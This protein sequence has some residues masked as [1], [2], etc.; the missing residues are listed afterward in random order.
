MSARSIQMKLSDYVAAFLAEQGVRYAFIVSGGASIHLLHSLAARDDIEPICPHHEQGGAMAADGYARVTGKI[1]CAIGT[2]G[3]GATNLITGIAGAWFDSIPIIFITGQVATYR[4]KGDTGVRQMGF[5]ETD[6]LPMVAP[7]TKYAAQIQDPMDIAYEL[8][9]AAH[10]AISGRQ[11]PVVIDIPDDLQRTLIDTETLRHFD[12]TTDSSE[13]IKSVTD[14][15]VDRVINLLKRAER[16]VLILGWGIRLS[17][18]T[19]DALNAIRTFG[20]PVL[21]SW[22]PKT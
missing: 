1:G 10:I 4:M 6:I 13:S 9:K 18:A 17:G 22:A 11:G 16:P 5:Q 8:E 2:S 14:S 20:V 7:I 19:G 3:P 15:E 12:P 21:L